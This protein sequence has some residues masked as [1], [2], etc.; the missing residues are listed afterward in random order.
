MA[1][2]AHG[3]ELEE[4]GY[5]NFASQNNNPQLLAAVAKN[6]TPRVSDSLVGAPLATGNLQPTAGAVG[7]TNAYSVSPNLGKLAL[8]AGS[9]AIAGTIKGNIAM[10]VIA[11]TGAFFGGSYVFDMLR[12]E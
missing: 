8:V 6:N 5:S 12:G 1:F 7:F 4:I 10:K 9:L 3:K 2:F 11:G